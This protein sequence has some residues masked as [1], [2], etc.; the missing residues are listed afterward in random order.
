[1]PL[2]SRHVAIADEYK[3]MML[4]KLE[5]ASKG[6]EEIYKLH[7]PNS[8]RARLIFD[9]AASGNEV[10][11]GT[12]TDT[13]IQGAQRRCSGTPKDLEDLAFASVREL[14]EFIRTKKFRR[15]R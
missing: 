12:Q 3:Q 11:N 4:D 9:P 8:C 5:R 15:S 13:H 14:G 1:M 10:R 6:Y 7:I 2:P